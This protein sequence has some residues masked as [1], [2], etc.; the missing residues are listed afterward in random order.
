[1]G[2]RRSL[3]RVSVWLPAL[4]C[5]VLLLPH[6]A[7][8]QT[9]EIFIGDTSP[10]DVFFRDSVSGNST[11]TIT[12]GTGVL[13]RWGVPPTTVTVDFH[14][15]VSGTCPP[16]GGSGLWDSGPTTP[17]TFT[18]G[19]GTFGTAFSTG[20]ATPLTIPFQTVGT[21]QYFCGFHGSLM[22]GTIIVEAGALHHFDVTGAPGTPVTA[23]QPFVVTVAARDQFNNLKTNYTGTVT[24][25]VSSPHP[26]G[27]EV[28]ANYTFVAGDQGD[29]DFTFTLKTAGSRTITIQDGGIQKQFT[30]TVNP[31]ATSQ[32]VLTNVPASAS[33]G[34]SFQVTVT[35]TDQ[36]TNT[37]SAYGGTVHFTSSDGTATLPADNTLI[38][39]TRNFNITMAT[40]GLQT[41][42][43]TD[44]VN[45][46]LTD[47]ESVTVSVACA[48]SFG[49]PTAITINDSGVV[50]PAAPYPSTITVAGLKSFS[51]VSVTLNGL[52]HTFGRDIDVLLVGPGGQKMVILSDSGGNNTVT[53]A[54]IT[55]EDS[56]P[57]LLPDVFGTVLV[58]GNFKPTNNADNPD[59]FPAPAPAAPYADPARTGTA[60]FAS[61]FNGTDPNGIWSLYVTDDQ[62]GGTGT[63]AGGWSLNFAPPARTFCNQSNIAIPVGG[64][65]TPYPSNLDVSGLDGTI[66]NISLRFDKLTHR[67]P[68]DLDMLLVSPA[69]QKMVVMSD[70]GGAG[71]GPDL[72]FTLD[73]SATVAVPEPLMGGVFRPTSL[74]TAG[75]DAFP[76]SG[77][78]PPPS[79][80]YAEPP[81]ASTATLAS[82][83]A[84][85][86][87]NGTWRL[88]VVDDVP[89]DAGSIAGGWALTFDL[90]FNTTT[91]MSSTIN[92]SVVGDI[93]IIQTNVTSS[94]PGTPTG[95][96]SYTLNGTP[97]GSASLAAGGAAF[98]FQPIAGT[99]NL[100]ATY[101]GDANFNP[102][103]SNL[104]VQVVNPGPTTTS[105][106]SSLNPSTFGQS[107]ILTA[108]VSESTPYS[109]TGTVTF[110]DGAA[111][112]GTGT[113]NAGVATFTTSALSAGSHTI[114]ATYNGDSNFATSTSPGLTQNVNKANTTTAVVTSGTPSTFGNSVTFTA[115]VSDSTTSVATGTVTFRDG[116]TVLGVGTLNASAVATFSTSALGGGSHTNINAVYAGDA[117]FNAST[118]PGITQ[119]VNK[120]T[121]S[122]SVISFL[123]PSSFTDEVIFRADVAATVTPPAA[124]PTGTVTFRDGLTSLG[125]IALS[126]GT[127]QISTST[128]AGGN[129]NITAVYNGDGNYNTQTSAILVQEVTA[130]ETATALGTSL[131]PSSFGQ[132]VMFTATVTSGVGTPAGTVTF[133]DG[134][135]PLGAPATL[136]GLG[137]ATLTTPSLTAGTHSITAIYNSNGSFA[138]STSTPVLQ[139]VNQSATTVLVTAP[140]QT[141]VFR[142]SITFT[143]AVDSTT[144][145]TP[146]GT[147]T[148][149]DGTTELGSASL[150]GVGEAAITITGLPVG[151]REI[152]VEYAGDSNFPPN[153]SLVVIHYR[154]PKPR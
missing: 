104:L 71:P 53:N 113:V 27:G 78:P 79:P 76:A 152:T 14:S 132:P 32:L 80:P 108:T 51:A 145:G 22:T 121:P 96:V 120:R 65:S 136:N 24:F 28:P 45:G 50:P 38:S 37:T 66:R 42:T 57:S 1:M 36:F 11:T 139:N 39:G 54:T 5:L 64:A 98:G 89:A 130:A 21:Y 81:P 33:A 75:S 135:T 142:E 129:H 16:C 134:A 6:L 43:V 140:Q 3:W 119:T 12:A 110:R 68:V 20:T 125:T 85:S 93:A 23:G 103:T 128:L 118:S 147:V 101:S 59:T 63:I 69:G 153:T 151:K 143:V 29:R 61:T 58:S 138:L 112:I 111:T 87:P 56:A 83:F 55:L 70:A 148:F 40:A 133:M 4:V 62:G 126:S 15:T 77:T 44:T 41:V 92:P 35:A 97:F 34:T 122:A 8:A 123:N 46:A 107:V 9:R 90:I 105:I 115:T 47:T 99:Y 2:A 84:G 141:S 146:T 49:N 144:S 73:D 154:S 94:G 19:P 109:P 31:A 74:G 88:Y 7:L 60:T 10:S 114:T 86:N 82:A 150:N 67:F 18:K 116:T 17:G 127:A 26:S 102:S 131:N 30:V 106:G 149:F 72:V 95:T 52:N 25:S 137:I 100:R 13:W 117:N 48:I 124:A 91:T